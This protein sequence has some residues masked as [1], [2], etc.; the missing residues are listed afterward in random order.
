MSQSHFTLGFPLKSPEEGQL[1][2][3][4]LPPLMP[5]LALHIA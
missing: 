2:V 5:Q 4:Q 1:L 3:D